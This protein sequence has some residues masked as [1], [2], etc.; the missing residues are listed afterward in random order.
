MQL[1]VCPRTVAVDAV[2]ASRRTSARH[3][4]EH[5]HLA[6]TCPD[7]QTPYGHGAHMLR[8]LRPGDVS[9]SDHCS[10]Q[11]VDSARAEDSEKGAHGM[12]RP[13]AFD[14]DLAL[15]RAMELF[16]KQGY[17]ATPLPHLTARLGIGGG[18]LYAAFG[19]KEGLICTGPETLLRRARRGSRGADGFRPR[20]SHDA[21]QCA[22]RAGPGRRVGP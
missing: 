22:A 20:H 11:S 19:S 7:Q 10:R 14:T 8:A 21:A 15:K 4:P 9:L 6:L 16:W 12:A 1:H 18:S 3:A 17:S 13:R 5:K 2:E